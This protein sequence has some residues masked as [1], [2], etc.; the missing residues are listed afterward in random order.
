MEAAVFVDF[1]AVA[2]GVPSEEAFPRGGT[3]VVGL[4]AGGCEFGAE[5][6][7]VRTVEA[8]VAVHIG[9]GVR[10]HGRD[11]Q[12]QAIGVEPNA[13]A[14]TEGIGL[15]DFAEAQEA[16]VKG[17]RGS[18]TTLGHGDVDVGELHLENFAKMRRAIKI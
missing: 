17:A 5:G 3:A 6:I 14:V 11:V 7:D 1:D 2:E 4:D 16:A 12:V 18:F 9:P 10:I 13:T 15:G 8:E